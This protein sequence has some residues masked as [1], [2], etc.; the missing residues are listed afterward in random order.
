MSSI[1]VLVLRRELISC[2]DGVGAV[3][4]LHLGD[5]LSQTVDAAV[6]TQE[7]RQFDVL[8]LKLEG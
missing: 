5:L 7:G 2:P 8:V 4:Q 3:V 6:G 1:Q